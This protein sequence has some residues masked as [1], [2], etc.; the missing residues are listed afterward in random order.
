MLLLAS[1]TRRG[2]ANFRWGKLPHTSGRTPHQQIS[3]LVIEETMIRG[4]ER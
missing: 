4:F 1:A 2:Y 3:A